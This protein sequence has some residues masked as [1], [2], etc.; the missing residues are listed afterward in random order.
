MTGGSLLAQATGRTD[1][2]GDDRTAEL[3]EARRLSK[4]Q[5]YMSVAQVKT[6]N[7]WQGAAPEVRDF[8]EATYFAGL[9]RAGMT[10]E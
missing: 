2:S 1:L 7:V 8:G 5:R 9:R 10:K 4:Y 6:L 3:A